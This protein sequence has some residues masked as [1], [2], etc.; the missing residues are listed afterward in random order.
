M[1]ARLVNRAL[2]DTEVEEMCG[3]QP[4]G[5]FRQRST[6]RHRMQRRAGAVRPA[7]RTRTKAV[8]STGVL[9]RGGMELRPGMHS[10]VGEP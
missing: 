2:C 3:P 7:R 1:A 4:A 8:A 6:A 9:G 10:G 5:A